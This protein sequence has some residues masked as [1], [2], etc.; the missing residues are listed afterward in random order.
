MNGA[1]RIETTFSYSPV[2][3]GGRFF[4][5][6]KLSSQGIRYE[7]S[8]RQ[9]RVPREMPVL[10]TL[11][12]IWDTGHFAIA[13]QPWLV[14]SLNFNPPDVADV[15]DL[16]IKFPHSD[17][18]IP[19]EIEELFPVLKQIFDIEQAVNPEIESRYAYVTI[20]TRPV[21]IGHTQRQ[22]PTRR[23]HVDGFQGA[24]I[25]PKVAVEHHYILT[26][27]L[28][29][30][31]H[32]QTFNVEHLNEAT[33]NFSDAFNEQIKWDSII[34]YDPFDLLFLDPYTVHSGDIA[35][36]DHA[37][38]FIRLSYGTRIYD[39]LGNSHNPMFD[40]SWNMLEREFAR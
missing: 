4:L 2:H 12:S 18:R 13:R 16:P 20:D 36:E 14:K 40:Y 5:L 9:L 23:A 22:G 33:D 38:T 10:Q 39:R 11:N 15:L 31:F 26:D 32:C 25:C 30:L 1:C 21:K 17:Y 7:A 35:P 37:R 34:K 8:P 24:R 3:S 29:T 28:P 6:P 19:R 27:Y